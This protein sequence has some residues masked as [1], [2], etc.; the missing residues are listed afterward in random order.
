MTQ[1]KWQTL[2]VAGLLPALVQCST[3]TGPTP[4]PDPDPVPAAITLTATD[5]VLARGEAVPFSAALLDSAGTPIPGATFTWSSRYPLIANTTADGVVI[6]VDVGD[7]EISVASSGLTATQWVQVRDTVIAQR[8]TLP[9]G[10]F[11]LGLSGGRVLVTLLNVDSVARVLTVGLTT[12][13]KSP[14][15][16][17]PTAVAFNPAGTRAYVA[18]QDGSLTV[19]DPATMTVVATAQI[20]GALQAVLAPGIDEL[21]VTSGD[22]DSIFAIDPNTLQI[23]DGARVRLGPNSI[24]RHPTLPR[25]YVNGSLTGTVYELDS[26][27]LDSLRAWDVRATPQ[28]MIVSADGA[29]LFVANEGGWLDRIALGTGV[30]LPRIALGAGGFGLALSPDGSRLGISL[31]FGGEVVVMST[32]T[33]AVVHHFYG[34]GDARRLAFTTDGTH[35]VVA[36]EAG[37]VDFIR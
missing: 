26:Q 11:G 33:L 10:P 4:T 5:T 35:L 6:G 1:H 22:R 32:A 21:W 2:L 20:G 16:H 13:G 9:G 14:T 29:T 18:N 30:V 37:W 27:T 15:G 8:L 17:F 31:G 24:A 36:N 28:G 19:L 34:A 3:D 7:T 12:T 25:L 23:R